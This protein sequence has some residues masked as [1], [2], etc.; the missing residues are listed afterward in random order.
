MNELIVTICLFFG[1]C[2]LM[3]GVGSS[4]NWIWVN[5]ILGA[6]L[7]LT[8]I[9]LTGTQLVNVKIIDDN[10]DKDAIHRKRKR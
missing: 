2:F 10:G 5:G 8:G 4:G 6:L 3:V 7:V 9:G 1:M